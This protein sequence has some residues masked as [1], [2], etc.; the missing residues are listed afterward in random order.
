MRQLGSTI[1]CYRGEAFTVRREF[2]D[3]DGT[4]LIISNKLRNPYIRFT[5][6]S[7]THKIE[8]DYVKNYWID[9]SNYQKYVFSD[10]IAIDDFNC[11]NI[12]TDKPESIMYRVASESL[13]QPDP[14]Y[15]LD[16]NKYCR[17]WAAR[18]SGSTIP[19][20][21]VYIPVT[22]LDNY[23]FRV[24]CKYV[25]TMY[26]AVDYTPENDN[27]NWSMNVGDAGQEIIVD[28]TRFPSDVKYIAMN[29]VREFSSAYIR[30]YSLK[31]LPK[32]N[33]I[34][35][36]TDGMVREYYTYDFSLEDWKPY[37]FSIIRKFINADTKMWRGGIYQYEIALCSGELM[38]D[39]LKRVYITLY[40]DTDV[41]SSNA[42]LAHYICKKRPDL[43]EGVNIDEPLVSYQT[44]QVLQE[45][46]KLI[47]K[48]N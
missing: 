13:P 30:L 3:T 41:P 46:A 34:Y 10:T 11:Y 28:V 21:K 32:E 40:L 36:K 35:Y 24:D 47:V 2:V 48:E 31:Y 8:G 20:L 23:V 9:V 22:R 19:I 37:N 4:P 17:K 1:E 25:G 33:Y 45:P 15:E 42:E 12:K 18:S 43:L 5:V 38:T 7:N 16:K 44:N 26:A 6:K 29:T 14:S 27:P 39:W